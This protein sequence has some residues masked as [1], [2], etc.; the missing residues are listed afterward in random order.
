[1]LSCDNLVDD[2]DQVCCG[3]TSVHLTEQLI[4]SR[5]FVRGTLGEVLI[6]TIPPRESQNNIV[7]FSPS[8]VSLL[9]LAVGKFVYDISCERGIGTKLSSFSYSALST[10]IA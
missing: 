7:T 3:E 5:D 8:G 10:L 6:G 4:G 1:M 2:I 9:D